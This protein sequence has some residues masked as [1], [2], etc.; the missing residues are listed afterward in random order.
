MSGWLLAVAVFMLV[1]LF[2]PVR[3]SSLVNSSIFAKV[4]GISYSIYLC[5]QS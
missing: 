2:Q 5:P 3:T 4:G 1:T